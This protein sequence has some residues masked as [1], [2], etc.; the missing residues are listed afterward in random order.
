M[1]NTQT[2]KSVF[3]VRNL[4]LNISY[5]IG[6]SNYYKQGCFLTIFTRYRPPGIYDLRTVEGH[7]KSSDANL[8]I[9]WAMTDITTTITTTTTT[10][11][12][13]K[14]VVTPRSSSTRGIWR[15]RRMATLRNRNS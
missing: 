5:S 4:H 15:G 14:H 7:L 6:Y 9:R 3:E 10:N 2:V 13:N 1:D 8:L 11:N 12:K